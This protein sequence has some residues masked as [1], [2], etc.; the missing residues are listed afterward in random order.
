MWD[1]I[2]GLRGHNLSQRQMLNHWA[3]QAPWG[4]K[5]LNCPLPLGFSCGSGRPNEGI[6]RCQNSEKDLTQFKEIVIRVIIR[7]EKAY[8]K[9][10]RVQV[11]A[12]EQVIVG[13]L[14]GWVNFYAHVV[15]GMAYFLLEMWERE[16]IFPNP[17]NYEGRM[18]PS[19]GKWDLPGS[20]SGCSLVC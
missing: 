20:R 4:Q 18:L 5:V 13:E 15:T 19:R 9:M 6:G 3:I 8:K 12:W 11:Q 2:P 1:S 7:N 14:R 17:F 16:G 10:K